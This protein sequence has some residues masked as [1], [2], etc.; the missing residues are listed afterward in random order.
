ME[1]T[2]IGVG[3]ACDCCYGNTSILIECSAGRRHLLDCGF[4]V[5]HYYFRY[6]SGP[7]ELDTLWISHF[8]GDHFFGVPQLLLCL[9]EMGRKKPLQVVGQEGVA[10]KVHGA[11]NLAYGRLARKLGYK[12]NFHVLLPGKKADIAGLEWRAAWGE[13]SQPCLALRLDDGRNSIFYSGDG[14][15]TPETAVLACRCDLL[16]HEA[17][18]L[19]GDIPGHGSVQG[20]I[21]FFRRTA[22]KRL[23]LVHLN[24]EVRGLG[25]ERILEMVSDVFGPLVFLPETG[26]KIFL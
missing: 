15:P 6:C 4:T 14:R 19:T 25:K 12:I 24:R 1:I 18:K 9:W 8:H 2:F 10:E 17:F 5:P 21:E 26:E 3:E 20:C 13:H 11:L 22:A 23:A 16:I 7:D